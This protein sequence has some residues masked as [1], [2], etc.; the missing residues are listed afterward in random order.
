M[1]N[2]L[3]FRCD[4]LL[5]V[6]SVLSKFP[7]TPL[8]RAVLEEGARKEEER[9]SGE[10]NGAQVACSSQ[11]AHRSCRTSLWSHFSLRF[12]CVHSSSQMQLQ[13]QLNAGWPR[14]WLNLAWKQVVEYSMVN[15]AL[16]ISGNEC[17]YLMRSTF[18]ISLQELEKNV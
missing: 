6:S 10:V 18:F 1:I 5:G 13:W 9:L 14:L 11:T 3:F 15:S 12:T 7:S 17:D 8:R 16:S 2:S 4:I